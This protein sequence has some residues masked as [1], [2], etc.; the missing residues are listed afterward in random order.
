M[1]VFGNVYV[2]GVFGFLVTTGIRL[3]EE[4]G[5]AVQVEGFCSD[6]MQNPL[7]ISKVLVY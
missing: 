3:R 5:D 2:H 6:C 4:E 1:A 7:E